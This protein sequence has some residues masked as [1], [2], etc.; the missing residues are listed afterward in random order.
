[1]I[2][3]TPLT[4]DFWRNGFSEDCPIYDMHG[5]MGAWKSIWFPRPDAEDM[6][7]SMDR[8]NVR[9]LC[10]AHHAALFA[11]DLG[12]APAVEAVR[13]FPERLRAY[14]AVN[15]HYPDALR[16]DLADFDRHRDVFVGLKVLAGYHNV[17]MTAPAYEAAFAFAH[18]RRLLVLMHTWGGNALCGPEIVRRLAARYP[19]AR[20]LCGHSFHGAWDEAV[21]LA[22]EFPNLSLELTAVLD[23]DRGAIEKLVSAGLSER[24]LF[25]T[26]LPWFAHHRGVGALLSADITD[27]DRHNILHRN[28]ERLLAGF[29]GLG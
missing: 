26:D 12:N 28:A 24:M 16:R 23:N 8:A 4:R 7:Y 22:R 25:G 15:P 20:L 21:A 19:E 29:P 14:L 5:H 27:D 1:V 10:F 6:V 13:R 9:L 3:D 2:N 17:A 11:P 18:E